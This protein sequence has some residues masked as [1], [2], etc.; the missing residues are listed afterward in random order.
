MLCVFCGAD[1]AEGNELHQRV[2]ATLTP[3]DSGCRQKKKERE[4][5][6]VFW[7]SPLDSYHKILGQTPEEAGASRSPALLKT[8]LVITKA[9]TGGGGGAQGHALVSSQP[10]SARVAPLGRPLT[11]SGDIRHQFIERCTSRHRNPLHQFRSKHLLITRMR[12]R[13]VGKQM[14]FQNT[15][16]ACQQAI[17]RTRQTFE[18]L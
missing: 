5:P 13:N 16:R 4:K 6:Q 9:N 18:Q 14:Q 7:P 17:C 3:G 11:S 12:R 1:R 10:G 8:Q 2:R 15:A